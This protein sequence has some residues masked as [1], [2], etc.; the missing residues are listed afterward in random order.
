M[1]DN[2]EESG[3][4]LNSSRSYSKTAAG[5]VIA[6]Q[7]CEMVERDHPHLQCHHL[8]LRRADNALHGQGFETMLRDFH[9]A[10]G[11]IAT[12]LLP[13]AA[14][15]P[16]TNYEHFVSHGHPHQGRHS[17]FSIPARDDRRLRISLRNRRIECIECIDVLGAIPADIGS[18][19]AERYRPQQPGQYRGSAHAFASHFNCLNY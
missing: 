10:S 17:C 15:L 2:S 11:G 1:P 16:V 4:F 18:Q 9:Q 3:D 8:T 7:L 14:H 6:T 12:S 13:N 19:L 5:T